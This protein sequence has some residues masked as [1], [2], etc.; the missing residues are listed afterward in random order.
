M[1]SL[2]RL[3][4][5][6]EFI[7]SGAPGFYR[8][9]TSLPIAAHKRSLLYA[10]STY[11]VTIL[12]GETG[13]G[14]T[15]QLP[16][17]LHSCGGAFTRDG[18]MVACTQPRRVAATTVALR[19][20]EEMGV[21][22]GDEVGYSIRFED[23]TGPQTRV[24]YM[25]DGMLLR[26]ALV[27]PLLSRYSV[28]MVDEAHERSLSTDILLGVLK[29]IRKKRKDLRLVIS[30]ATLQ[31]EEFLRFFAEGEEGVATIV[32][33]E[34]R[35]FP[36]DCL[37]LEEPTEDYVEKAVQTVFD[38]HLKEG[39]GDILVFLTGRE[40]IERAVRTITE[41]SSD[42]H[43]R[44]P[45]LLPLPLYAGL[46]L[47][48]QLA[49]FDPAPENHR[50][51]ILSTNIA[52]ASVTI[53]GIA[54]VIDSGFAK[55]RCYNPSTGISTL[56][57]IPIS[58]AS[59]T[60]RAGRAGRTRPG[61]CYR[62]YTEK[63]HS[64]LGDVA[65]AEIQ[66]SD[67]AGTIL[68]LKALGIDNIARFDFVAAPPAELVVRALELLYSL[69]AL[70]EYARLTRPLGLQMAELPLDPMLSRTLLASVS[71]GCFSQ[72]L[73]IA[74]M[75]TV[76]NV[77]ITHADS[78]SSSE[79]KKRL[80]AVDEGDHLTLLNVYTAFTTR[81]KRS[82]AWCR[83]HSLNYKA[84]TRAV[85]VR[86]QL[87]RYLLRFFP[88]LE[89]T[90]CD[91]ASAETIR[92][93]LVS[94]YFAHAAQMRADGT[95]RLVGGGETQLWAHPSSVLFNRK[96]EWVVFHEIVETGK[97]TYIR[98]LTKVEKEWLL[99]CAPEYYKVNEGRRE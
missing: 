70:D 56:T 59:A 63:A 80:F 77:F 28:I 34:G 13:S 55:L 90:S 11:P 39:E 75:T 41:R 1:A 76:Q 12:I 51:V 82:S 49:V 44:A 27:D 35:H 33:V 23:M 99:Q 94:G 2:D 17:Y 78:S 8:P 54:F 89:S 14:K 68:Q 81:G 91:A 95:F 83:D 53:D 87:W 48:Q 29:K 24:K 86:Q 26:E 92:K 15:T 20:A 64:S 67:L 50:K 32:G 46:S 88:D 42:L 66:R 97:K 40:E 3:T 18:K 25:T 57:A 10:V 74:A 16:Q 69:G 96:A 85:S 84:L 31:A 47:A 93:C 52:E 4:E 60:Q 43:P 37:Y 38:I 79:N 61:K 65:V 6:E 30:S 58:K 21:A 62:L 45:Q 9:S 72:M 7:P 5:A 19:V 36:V 73:S 22:V 98:D 71:L